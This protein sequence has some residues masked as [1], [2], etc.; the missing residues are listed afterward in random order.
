[1]ALLVGLNDFSENENRVDGMNDLS[2]PPWSAD[3]DENIVSGSAV[4]GDCEQAVQAFASQAN[5]QVTE[6]KY[7]ISKKWG[8]VLRAKVVVTF[9]GSSRATL[10]NCWSGSGPGVEIFVKMADD[11]D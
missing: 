4:F 9:E 10:V 5:G 7:S 3:S 1:L 8:N 11:A 6:R 2:V